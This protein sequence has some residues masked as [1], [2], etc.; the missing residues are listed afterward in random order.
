MAS[1]QLVERRPSVEEYCRLISAVGWKPRDAEAISRALAASLFAIC[2]ETNGEV[3]GMGRVIGDG[4]LHYYL[5]D[6]VV[7]PAHQHRGLGSEIVAALTKH[8]ESIPFKNTLAC[9]FPVAG[10]DD[11]YER[12]GD[13]AP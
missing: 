3:I 7:V 1:V 13:K 2:A 6:V 10:T 9:L 8:V 4:G 5:T 12:V 11:V